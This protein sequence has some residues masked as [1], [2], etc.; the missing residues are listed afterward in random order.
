M[1]VLKIFKL[2]SLILIVTFAGI[3]SADATNSTAAPGDEQTVSLPEKTKEN[4]TDTKPAPTPISMPSFESGAPR[5]YPPKMAPAKWEWVELTTGEWLK[6]TIK[7][8]RH[9]NME[10]DSDNF[11]TIEIDMKDVL[12]TYSSTVNTFVFTNQRLV[13]GVGRITKDQ[14]I[15]DTAAGK[16]YYPRQQLISVVVGDRT[17]FKLWTGTLTAG[18]SSTSGNTNQTT[19]NLQAN[20]KRRG[21]FLRIETNYYG[22]IGTTN[23]VTNVQNQQVNLQADLFIYDRFYLIPASFEFYSDIFSN[24]DTRYKPGVGVGYQFFERSE[25]EWQVNAN[26]L[27]QRV[28]YVSTTGNEPPVFE[29][30]AFSIGSDLKYDI[31]SDITLHA[32]YT[33]TLAVPATSYLD[34]QGILK[35]D[36]DITK[37]VSVN[38]TAN[39]TRIGNP[40]ASSDGVVPDKNDLILTFGVSLDF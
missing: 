2:F 3:P 5:W 22:N 37:H 17:E 10:F 6:G 13:I 15:I 4:S 20:L 34:Q 35:L 18:V 21:A 28:R 31:T 39:W 8:I 38:S 32:N 40:I 33:I 36:V 25:L 19:V 29:S 23:D 12:Q 30:A 16:M 14:V 27:Y 24:I 1:N 26:L 11:D 7:V 9:D